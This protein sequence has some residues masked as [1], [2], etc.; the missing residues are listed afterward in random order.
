MLTY[1]GEE[2]WI[3]DPIGL[4][5]DKSRVRSLEKTNNHRLRR[6]RRIFGGLNEVKMRNEGEQ[7]PEAEE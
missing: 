3:G 4:K 1:L 2:V 7:C 5:C 6:E